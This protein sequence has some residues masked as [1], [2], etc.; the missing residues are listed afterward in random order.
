[1]SPIQ[2]VALAAVMLGLLLALLVPRAE[3]QSAPTAPTEA[4]ALTLSNV[5]ALAT[6]RAPAVASAA[7][8]VAIARS[9][10]DVAGMLPN[11]RLGIGG[12][13]NYLA[14]LDFYVLLPIFGQRETAE[15]AAAALADATDAAVQATRLDARLAASIAWIELWSLGEEAS[16]AADDAAR[17]AHLAEAAQVRFDQGAGPRLDVLR[18]DAESRRAAAELASIADA[19]TASSARLEALV[20]VA[21]PAGTTMTAGDPLEQVPRAPLAAEF[22]A[23]IETHP[24]NVRVRGMTH[25]ADS[26]VERDQ[27]ARW[28]RVGLS[29]SDWV[30]R[31]TG[32]HD[33]RALVTFDVPLF[34]AP[35]V[36]RV[37]RVRDA[38][39][40]DAEGARVTLRAALV[41]ALADV[42]RADARCVAHID[43]VLP[44][45]REVATLSA[46]AYAEGSIDLA[47][48]LAAEQARSDA[49]RAVL[50]CR[51]ERARALA[52]LE[53]A[54]GHTD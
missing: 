52:R 30:S 8:Q 39:R 11:P 9:D 50:L 33:V 13:V 26:A 48:T 25:A 28:P 7:A 21:R 15:D 29:V 46:E 27:R 42:R 1:M 4:T 31:Q 18:S 38:A 54:S 12:G 10:A 35:R 49:E 45:A 47:A 19:R 44:A 32:L 37:E 5:R 53:H 41:A 36:H 6:A 23:L 17:R 43:S 16:I 20:G 24:V 34:D 51:A 40:T 3:A 14:V 22:D 2:D